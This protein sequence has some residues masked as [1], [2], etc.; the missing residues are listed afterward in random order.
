MASA[1]RHTDEGWTAYRPMSPH[2]AAQI[3]YMSQDAKDR[4]RIDN[5]PETRTSWLKVLPGRSKGD[6]KHFGPWYCYLDG[7]HADYPRAY[8]RIAI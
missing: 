4:Q 3:W 1:H 7:R 2:H 6:D 8:P 5:I